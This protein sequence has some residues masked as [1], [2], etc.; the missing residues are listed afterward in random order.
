ML[1]DL[2][3]MYPIVQLPWMQTGIRVLGFPLDSDDHDEES[4]SRIADSIT[5][6]L[7]ALDLLE[8]GLFKC[9]TSL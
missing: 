2:H 7:P 5:S 8:D 3:A 1:A 9:F 6:E 4:L